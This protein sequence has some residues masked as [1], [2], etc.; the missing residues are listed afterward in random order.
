MDELHNDT[1][2]HQVIEFHSI[3][4]L[5]GKEG[6]NYLR[7]AFSKKP[8]SDYIK[9]IPFRSEK[10]Q[11]HKWATCY[12]LDYK[13]LSGATP[14][15]PQEPAPIE[16]TNIVVKENEAARTMGYSKSITASIPVTS[17][18]VTRFLSFARSTDKVT[19]VQRVNATDWV[20]IKTSNK[21]IVAVKDAVVILAAVYLTYAYHRYR[22]PYYTH[23]KINPPNKTVL[24]ISALRQALQKPRNVGTAMS[25]R[26]ALDVTRDTVYDFIGNI[27]NLT[28]AADIEEAASIRRRVFNCDAIL[29]T[30]PNTDEE[31]K[32]AFYDANIFVIEWDQELFNSIINS[33]SL[34][35]LPKNLLTL[36]ATLVVLYLKLRAN[37]ELKAKGSGDSEMVTGLNQFLHNYLGMETNDFLKVI[38]KAEKKEQEGVEIISDDPNEIH[39]ALF[40]FLVVIKSQANELY[41]KSI[42]HLVFQ[43][44]GVSSNHD[45]PTHWNE[46]SAKLMSIIENDHEV[47]ARQV[48][49]QL[50]VETTNGITTVTDRESGNLCIITKFTND[51]L[52]NSFATLMQSSTQ[53]KSTLITEF[54]KLR[55]ECS[56]PIVS[57]KTIEAVIADLVAYYD[58]QL[59]HGALTNLLV[60]Y[61]S[62]HSDQAQQVERTVSS[63]FIIDD[64]I[65]CDIVTKVIQ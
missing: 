57:E 48:E 39:M 58:V 50:D 63:G 40:G 23:N 53:S 20:T 47:N 7:R 18:E 43:Y 9:K 30:L 6:D 52:I 12:S 33:K 49:R 51:Q 1:E 5:I 17:A 27:S 34:L 37:K 24:S 41:I 54:K 29:N 31:A 4:E 25:I 8:L 19:D 16:K 55:A 15:V 3:L 11:A 61:F 14:V 28:G 26:E 44:A 56:E 46:L 2:P 22:L 64:K 42:R 38:R 36:D 60:I 65:L 32:T 35:A 21:R 45:A 59:E 10:N 13:A 62:D